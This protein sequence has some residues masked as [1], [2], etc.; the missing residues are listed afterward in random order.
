MNCNK[1]TW[2]FYITRNITFG[3]LLTILYFSLLFAVYAPSFILLLPIIWFRMFLL[4][5]TSYTFF[6]IIVVILTYVLLIIDIYFLYEIK[7]KKN[8]FDVAGV[9][10]FVPKISN[11]FLVLI[12]G[13]QSFVSLSDTLNYP[14]R[15]EAH[16]YSVQS[17]SC[18]SFSSFMLILNCLIYIMLRV[19]VKGNVIF[20]SIG[21]I[22]LS[23][24]NLINLNTAYR[25]LS[26]Y[27]NYFGMTERRNIGLYLI[28]FE[29]AIILLCIVFLVIT[30]VKTLIKKDNVIV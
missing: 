14:I 3:V 7:I 10:K 5:E 12:I 30:L 21:L 8:E 11:I 23:I 13:I 28:Y 19:K 22:I 4:I 27:I 25:W 15:L 2:L 29:F 20:N 24:L 1:K 18:F 17:I 9:P 16:A 26:D 6:N